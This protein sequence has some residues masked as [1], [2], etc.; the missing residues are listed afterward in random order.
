MF[1]QSIWWVGQHVMSW[2][3]QIY[4]HNKINGILCNFRLQSLHITHL[5][6]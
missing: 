5:L 1:I 2:N 3:F 6:V 4:K